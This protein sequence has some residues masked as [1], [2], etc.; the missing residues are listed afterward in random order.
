MTFRTRIITAS[1]ISQIGNWLT[2]LA[3]MQFTQ[4]HFGAAATATSF[5]VQSLPAMFAAKAIA[6]QIP[7]T[8]QF[9]AWALI[10]VGLA[11]LTSGLAAVGI[12]YVA[13]LIYLAVAT[14]LRTVSSNLFMTLVSVNIPEGHRESTFTAL[15]ATGSLTLVVSPAIGGGLAAAFGFP[16][17]LLLDAATFLVATAILASSAGSSP[18]KS[19]QH[20]EAKKAPDTATASTEPTLRE[21]STH[22]V[23]FTRS[24]RCWWLYCVAGAGINA[25]EMPVLNETHHLGVAGVGWAL[26]SYG[27][28]GASAFAAGA[29]K[30]RV[31]AASW[32]LS[33]IYTVALCVWFLG[34]YVGVYLGFAVAGMAGGLLSGRVRSLFDQISR[35]AKVKP[36]S[37]WSWANKV[38]LISNVGTY[39]LAAGA[40]ALGTSVAVSVWVVVA[41][42]GVLSVQLAGVQSHQ[43]A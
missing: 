38:V 31:P 15:G 26:T 12:S 2:F 11:L 7:A 34:G 1:T 36:V 4:Q 3:V 32:L 33:A 10:Q 18:K 25:V 40:F 42:C 37:I 20:Q 16:A 21:A 30:I 17:L 43:S 13:V 41:I 14:M 29:A 39:G 19:E 8:W 24:L 28:G 23:M 6:Q 5:L 22:D 27:V 9:R 35:A